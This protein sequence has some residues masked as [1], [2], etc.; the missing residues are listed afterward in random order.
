MLDTSQAR[1]FISSNSCTCKRRK[2]N[3]PGRAPGD[4]WARR[5]YEAIP[6]YA[7]KGGKGCSTLLTLDFGCFGTEPL[8]VFIRPPRTI[9]RHEAV[10]A[11]PDN[12]PRSGP[13]AAPR[14]IPADVPR[15]NQRGMGFEIQAQAVL[16]LGSSPRYH[17]ICATRDHPQ[18]VIDY[19]ALA[20][21][22]EPLKVAGVDVLWAFL[23]VH[24]SVVGDPVVR[25]HT[26]DIRILRGLE[27][28]GHPGRPRTPPL[29]G[30]HVR[31]EG[32]HRVEVAGVVWE[33]SGPL[34][35]MNAPSVSEYEVAELLPQV[36][37]ALAVIGPVV[38][39]EPGEEFGKTRRPG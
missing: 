6:G 15:W 1:L 2:G 14:R 28:G 23:V 19:K 26:H 13:V 10:S 31:R 33:D 17:D 35:T 12:V 16:N 24:P 20:A 9:R 25:V 29:G 18:V 4:C 8:K 37:V 36:A 27:R 22:P 38:I 30:S 32:K 21:F 7:S 39:W 5:Q 11:L 3:P 34:S